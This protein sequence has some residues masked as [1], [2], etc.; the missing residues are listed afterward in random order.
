M[1]AYVIAALHPLVSLGLGVVGRDTFLVII[2]IVVFKAG[3]VLTLGD[4]V[5]HML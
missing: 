5:R 3:D 4:V 1:S 2:Q